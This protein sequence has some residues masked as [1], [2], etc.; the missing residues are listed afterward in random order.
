MPPPLGYGIGVTFYS[1]TSDQLSQYRTKF[2]PVTVRDATYVLDELCN[3][4]SRQLCFGRGEV[5]SSR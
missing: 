1:W 3:N 5:I 2:V 4:E